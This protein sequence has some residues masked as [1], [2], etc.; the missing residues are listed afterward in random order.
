M[1]IDIQEAAD[2]GAVGLP[3]E[4]DPAAQIHGARRGLAVCVGLLD[5]LVQEH[6]Q[7][8]DVALGHVGVGEALAGEVVPGLVI[9]ADGEDPRLSHI[10]AHVYPSLFQFAD[11]SPEVEADDVIAGHAE[12]LDQ[13][14]AFCSDDDAVD[15]SLAADVQTRGVCDGTD[16]LVDPSDQVDELRLLLVFE[17]VFEPLFALRLVSDLEQPAGD[18]I[19]PSCE[20]LA[21]AAVV[22][23]AFLQEVFDDLAR[24]E[25]GEV[26]VA[27]LPVFVDLTIAL[28]LR[29]GV[30]G[31]Q[32][33]FAFLLADLLP[34]LDEVDSTLPVVEDRAGL[35]AFEEVLDHL[36]S[37][38]FDEGVPADMSAE[39]VLPVFGDPLGLGELLGG[40]FDVL[41]FPAD[42]RGVRALVDELGELCAVLLDDGLLLCDGGLGIYNLG[43]EVLLRHC[44]SSCCGV[45][46]CGVIKMITLQV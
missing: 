29:K 31:L 4:V 22:E 45:F 28:Q 2:Q 38:G 36:R 23:A 43:F 5:V 41:L 6:D 44:V 17:D 20:L 1:A 39:L 11:R 25:V 16:D 7:G 37:I 15:V 34:V 46:F 26:A 33:C 19:C 32:A 40:F 30:E 9:G 13:G 24:P 8:E 42:V 10:C 35:P 21:D 12:G 18:L 3:F 27:G 14:L